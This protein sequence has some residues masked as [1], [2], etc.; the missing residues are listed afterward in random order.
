MG[1]GR[2]SSHLAPQDELRGKA[3]LDGAR[4]LL[5]SASGALPEG[6]G[7]KMSGREISPPPESRFYLFARPS[8]CLNLQAMKAETWA[9]KK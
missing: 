2:Y 1:G 4:W 8:F 6:E 5:C 7:K 3:H 9:D